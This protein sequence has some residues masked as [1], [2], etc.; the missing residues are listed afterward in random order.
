MHHYAPISK[1]EA[2]ADGTIKVWGVASAECEDNDGETITAAAMEEAL[3]G[4]MEW[5]AIREMHQPIAA[6][7]CIEA[8][9]NKA[10]GETLI[11]AHITDPNSVKKVQT[12]TLKGFSIGGVA[13]QTDPLNKKIITGLKL[14]EI[15]LVDKPANPKAAITLWKADMSTSVQTPVAPVVTGEQLGNEIEAIVKGDVMSIG[16]LM[17]LVKAAATAKGM[18]EHDVVKGEK[19]EQC[20]GGIAKGMGMDALLKRYFTEQERHDAALAGKAMPDGSFPIENEEDLKNAIQA[21]GRAKDPAAAKKHIETRAKEMGKEDLL[22][23]DWEKVAKAAGGAINAVE[24]GSPEAPPATAGVAPTGGTNAEG[25]GTSKAA[26]TTQSDPGAPGTNA[27]LGASGAVTKSDVVGPAT[28][29]GPDAAVKTPSGPGTIPGG[30]APNADTPMLPKPTIGHLVTFKWGNEEVG[31]NIADIRELPEGGNEVVVKNGPAMLAVNSDKLIHH[32]LNGDKVHWT[33]TLEPQGEYVAAKAA[34]SERITAA[35]KKAFKG[36]NSLQKGMW[37][38]ANWADTLQDIYWIM[39]DVKWESVS[40]DDEKDD[41]L[42]RRIAMW[43]NAGGKLMLEYAEDQLKEMFTG[44]ADPDNICEFVI[45]LC[46]KPGEL[47]KFAEGGVPLGKLIQKAVGGAVVDTTALESVIQK[48]AD[49]AVQKVT[50]ELQKAHALEL[51]TLQKRIKMLEDQP[52]PI[53]GLSKA[54]GRTED[55]QGDDTNQPTVTPVKKADGSTDEAATAIK[56][57]LSQPVPFQRP[58]DR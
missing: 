42:E 6:G 15:S 3:P 38:V 8:T 57:S 27:A 22:P 45:E 55:G 23:D 50:G 25:G 29:G 33:V 34:Q 49:A 35:L 43:L 13:T 26:G 5:G 56:K 32:E 39:K 51:D 19:C 4:Y 11:C 37:T 17:A 53:K 12:K 14:N 36:E 1:V 54:V 16:D 10:T 18:C 20:E 47:K 41:S 2:Q 21:H 28:A 58:I 40:E 7:N 48:A 31:G 46:S 9:V 52:A 24:P 30:T 44:V